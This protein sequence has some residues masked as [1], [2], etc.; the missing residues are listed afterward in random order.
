MTGRDHW[1]ESLD[2]PKCGKTGTAQFSQANG[3]P[4]HE[5]DQDIR[6]DL[7]PVGFKAFLTEFGNSFYCASCGTS[8]VH[9]SLRRNEQN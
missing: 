6:V 1:T 8:V 2:C 4:F 7:V 3:Q 5:G 9:K